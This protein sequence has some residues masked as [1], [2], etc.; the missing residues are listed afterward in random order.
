MH[1]VW[2]T[3]SVRRLFLSEIGVHVKSVTPSTMFPST[4]IDASSDL[5]QRF[6]TL[7]FFPEA[8]IPN[9]MR[10]PEY[11]KVILTTYH[12]VSLTVAAPIFFRLDRLLKIYSVDCL[13]RNIPKRLPKKTDSKCHINNFFEVSI[14]S[15][16]LLLLEHCLFEL[17]FYFLLQDLICLMFLLLL[18]MPI[19]N[20]FSL[21]LTLPYTDMPVYAVYLALYVPHNFMSRGDRRLICSRIAHPVACKM[22]DRQFLKKKRFK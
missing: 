14:C 5:V 1:C 22:K 16:K 8:F 9:L 7:V 21:T 15:D 13:L 17:V 12:R 3:I 6:R 18:K 10:L 11:L 4:L 2:F 19:T 20:T